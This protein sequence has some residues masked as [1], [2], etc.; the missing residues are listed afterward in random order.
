METIDMAEDGAPLGRDV[1]GERER[2]E[3]GGVTGTGV[4]T[5]RAARAAATSVALGEGGTKSRCGSRMRGGNKAGKRRF[6]CSR[7]EGGKGRG[8]GGVGVRTYPQFQQ[9][10]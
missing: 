2:G 7:V 8:S 5:A 1:G 3:M 9:E 4:L 6:T 10:S